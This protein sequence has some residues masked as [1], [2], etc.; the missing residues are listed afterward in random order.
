M[1]GVPF[2]AMLP[3]QIPDKWAEF[4]NSLPADTTRKL[5][6]HDIRHIFKHFNPQL[7]AKDARIEELTEVLKNQRDWHSKK[8][9]YSFPVNDGEHEQQIKY[10]L[11]ALKGKA[12]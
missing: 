5:S 4:L 10:L 3:P 8:S 6:F 7:A 11:A 12:S 9:V 2:F 1:S